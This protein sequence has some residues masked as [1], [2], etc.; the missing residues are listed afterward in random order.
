M[1]SSR[2][3]Q[4]LKML[5]SEAFNNATEGV[6]TYDFTAAGIELGSDW[7]TAYAPYCDNDISIVRPVPEPTTM[8]LLGTG[9]FCFAWG[10]R[11]KKQ[12]PD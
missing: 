3:I 1:V 12:M 6:L 8:V 5:I 4:Q 2:M 9:L 10:I 11:R 7:V